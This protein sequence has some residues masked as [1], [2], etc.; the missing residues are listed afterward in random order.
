M[1]AKTLDPAEPEAFRLALRV[2][3]P[4]IDPA[5]LSR[6]FGIQPAYSYRAGSERPSRSSILKTTV[7]SE[8]YWVG[9]LTAAAQPLVLS[10]FGSERIAQR[11]VAVVKK[12]LTWALTST[13]A[14]L[15]KTHADLLRGIRAQGGEV[16]LLVTICGDSLDN[17]SL[18]PEVSRLFGELGVGIEFEIVND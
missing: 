13:C 8:S 14:R 15:L 18:P 16:T 9:E 10:S 11:H 7:H 17:F 3:H 12:N 1:E 2:R 4:S 5:E 6:A